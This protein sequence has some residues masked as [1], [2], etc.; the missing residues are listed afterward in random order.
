MNT[1]IVPYSAVDSEDVRH[2]SS[3][4]M[5]CRINGIDYTW[6]GEWRDSSSESIERAKFERWLLDRGVAA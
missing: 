5:H 2:T 1:P 6:N 3:R 4:L